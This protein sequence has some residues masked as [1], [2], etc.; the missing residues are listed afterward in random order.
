MTEGSCRE[1]FVKYFNSICV[2]PSIEKIMEENRVGRELRGVNTAIGEFN[3]IKNSLRDKLR[4]AIRS[5]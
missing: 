1:S 3:E 2:K 5:S 4:D